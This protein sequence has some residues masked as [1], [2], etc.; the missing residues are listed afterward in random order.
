MCPILSNMETESRFYPYQWRI[1]KYDPAK[2][3]ERGSYTGED[4]TMAQQIGD[5][6]NDKTF[7]KEEY[8][9]MEDR[10]VAAAERFF[11]ASGLETLTVRELQQPST[12]PDYITEHDLNDIENIKLSEGQ[13]VT[14]KEL[15]IIMR[16]MLRETLWCKL[17]N[18]EKFFIHVGWDYYMYIGCSENLEDA[19]TKTDADGLYV[20]KFASPYFEK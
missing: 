8:L 6:F 1:T 11:L 3:D 9:G 10:Y 17:E 5:V 20:E 7:T 14:A 15:G 16:L 19:V 18:S 2:R 13:Q 4:W 12:S